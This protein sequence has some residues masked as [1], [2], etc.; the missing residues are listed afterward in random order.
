MTLDQAFQETLRPIVE[1]IEQLQA[2]ATEQLEFAGRV[3]ASGLPAAQAAFTLTQLSQLFPI[4]RDTFREMFHA[5]TLHGIQTGN[6][7]LIFRWSVLEWMGLA[8]PAKKKAR[9]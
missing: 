9:R 4:D 8:D 7:I 1:R 6:R 3:D 2:H 5:G